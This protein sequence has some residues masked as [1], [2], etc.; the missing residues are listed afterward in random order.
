MN[1]QGLLDRY[2]LFALGLM[3]SASLFRGLLMAGAI[4]ISLK[5]TRGCRSIGVY[6]GYDV[7]AT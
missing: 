6:T 1:S 5:K 3:R 2:A 4:G 7:A